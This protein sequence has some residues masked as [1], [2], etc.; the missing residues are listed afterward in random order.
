MSSD[1]GI[2]TTMVSVGPQDVMVHPGVFGLVH[3]IEYYT[4]QQTFGRHRHLRVLLL[5][6]QDFLSE[7]SNRLYRR[8]RGNAKR[9]LNGGHFPKI[10]IYS[11]LRLTF[12]GKNILGI[13][14]ITTKTKFIRLF[15]G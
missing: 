5:A 10:G 1:C 6:D 4:H 15:T 2:V 11:A 12:Q 8:Y 3:N 14:K 9:S 13:T 7:L